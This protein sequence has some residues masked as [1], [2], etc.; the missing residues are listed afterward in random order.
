MPAFETLLYVLPRQERHSTVPTSILVRLF[1]GSGHQWLIDQLATTARRSV[2]HGGRNFIPDG[3]R[4]V[5]LTFFQFLPPPI[6]HALELGCGEGR[7]CCDVMA[8]LSH[9]RG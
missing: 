1:P 2:S 8:R 7:V 9:D 6:G 3:V 5:M 4:Q